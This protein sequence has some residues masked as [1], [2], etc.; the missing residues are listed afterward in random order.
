MQSFSCIFTARKRSLGQGN[1]FLS[2]CYSVNRG[3]YPNIHLDRGGVWRGCMNGCVRGG[4]EC[5]DRG[6]VYLPPP[7]PAHNQR[8]LPK[9]AVHILRELL[10]CI[11]LAQLFAKHSGTILII[12]IGCTTGYR[13][14]DIWGKYGNHHEISL[15]LIY[16]VM[17]LSFPFPSFSLAK[18]QPFFLK[19]TDITDY[20]T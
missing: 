10:E 16:L 9:R 5:V 14:F 8:R 6:G 7:P 15:I 19:Y 17:W 18:I 11:L 1:V 20:I 3:V 12:V 2:V 4:E 13:D